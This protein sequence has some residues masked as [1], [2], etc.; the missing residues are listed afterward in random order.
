MGMVFATRSCAAS[1]D[2]HI[3]YLVYDRARRGA[4]F[5]NQDGEPAIYGR[6]AWFCRRGDDRRQLLVA[7]GAQAIEMSE[8]SDWP[9]WMPAAIGFL[10]GGL[11][12][13]LVNKML[14][15]RP[16]RRPMWPR[17]STRGAIGAARCWCWPLRCTTSRKDSPSALPSAPSPPIFLRLADRSGGAGDQGSASRISR[18]A[19]PWP[20]RCA[21][22]ECRGAKVS[23]T[24]NCPA[25]SNRWQR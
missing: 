11:F 12:L 23:S 16:T 10:L 9:A 14:P 7:S 24:A 8:G 15:H 17:A 20:C 6:D 2:R 21:V 1:I 18:K 13:W 5:L 22:K 25:C 19:S 3:V 4:C